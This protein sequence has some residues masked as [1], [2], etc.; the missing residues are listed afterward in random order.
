M[1][2]LNEQGLATLWGK[3][4]GQVADAKAYADANFEISGGDT[5]TWDGNL[6]GSNYVDADGQIFVHVSDC[7][8]TIENF[9]D[10][11]T[12]ITIQNGVAT[13]R[14]FTS[15]TILPIG[16]VYCESSNMFFII[17]PEDNGTFLT[18]V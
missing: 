16:N 17:I 5:I 7:V 18:F 10:G 9:A 11:G 2:F 4:K 8:P 3:V 1:A 12:I 13:E 6:S 14:T 15:S